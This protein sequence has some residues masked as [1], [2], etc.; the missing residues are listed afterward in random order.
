MSP[1]LSQAQGCLT[2][3]GLEVYVRPGG[4]QRFDD[5]R[6]SGIGCEHEGC[7]AFSVL[8]VHVGARGNEFQ[9]D[10]L[11]PF[12]GRGDQGR[13]VFSVPRVQMHIVRDEFFDDLDNGG[14]DAVFGLD[15]ALEALVNAFKSAARGYGIEKRVLLLHGPVGSSKSTIARITVPIFIVAPHYHL[16]PREHMQA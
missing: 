4:D 5:P 3:A 10:P 2:P 1:V 13:V 16:R 9:D 14:T 11:V 12:Y 8:H 15:A 6:M 7:C